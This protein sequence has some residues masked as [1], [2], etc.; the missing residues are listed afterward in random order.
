MLAVVA[1]AAADKL[2]GK[3]QRGCSQLAAEV[4]EFY[5]MLQ[6]DREPRMGWELVHRRQGVERL[7][8]LHRRIDCSM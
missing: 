7:C 5:W 8:R 3:N 1:A 2:A 6:K 4:A